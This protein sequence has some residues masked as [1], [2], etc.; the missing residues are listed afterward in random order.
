MPPH[1]DPK[2]LL[3]FAKL[4]QERKGVPGHCPVCNHDKLII[5]LPPLYPEGVCENCIRSIAEVY[6]VGIFST[7]A[8][9]D[10][11]RFMYMVLDT[12]REHIGIS[13]GNEGTTELITTIDDM[14]PKCREL[15]TR[16][17]ALG[18]IKA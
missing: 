9:A 12:Y 3:A 15:R 4:L 11:K 14:Y 2:K 13:T 18:Y 16:F 17:F 6:A 5:K 1:D 7:R 8:E 10:T